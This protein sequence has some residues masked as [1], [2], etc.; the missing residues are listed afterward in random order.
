MTTML[1]SDSVKAA[2]LIG[3]VGVILLA[4]NNSV[5][6]WDQDEA[7]YAGF[8]LNIVENGD[9]LI[10]DF[11]WSDVH[12]KPPLHFWNIALSYKVFGI[13]EF[14]VRLPSV[15]FILLT[16][17]AMYW[18]GRKVFG[19]RQSLYGISILATSFLVPALAKI[20]VTDGTLLFFTTLCA[21]AILNVLLYRNWVWVIVFW[22]SLSLALLTKG[23]PVIL[24]AGGF[25]LLAL[26]FHPQRKNLIILHPWF[27]LP[28]SLLPL[29]AWAFA[30]LQ[31]PQGKVFIEWMLDWY[32]LKRIGGSVFGQTGPPG[33]HL[34]GI[35][36]FFI[37]YFIFLPGAFKELVMGFW[38]GD[39]GPK[40][41]LGVWFIAGWFIFE[42]SPSKL[43][44]YVVAAHVP[45]AL[46]I[47]S[48]LA[49]GKK[50]AG[51][52]K[53]IQVIV[54]SLLIA[55]LAIAPLI[56][57]LGLKSKTIVLLSA[58]AMVVGLV[59]AFREKH[60]RFSLSNRIIAFNFLFQSIFWI[61]V[62]PTI[63][64]LKNS[65]LKV[66][67]IAAN[68]AGRDTGVILA[69]SFSNPPSLPFY[70]RQRFDNLLEEYDIDNLFVLHESDR[71]FLF[72]LTKE[73]KDL[74]EKRYGNIE[75]VEIEASYTDRFEK[76]TYYL[77]LNK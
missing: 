41:L 3:M 7:A 71:R 38:T 9:W 50:P 29:F 18:G 19:E 6:L 43:P 10:P 74:L 14:A 62:L 28:L 30:C 4:N 22:I 52:Y 65:T 13:N 17:V 31:D 16:L 36:I 56:L 21:L 2:I 37:P 60:C 54:W 26:I 39:R 25:G 32:I 67:T 58:A 63:E 72:V 55:A 11:T 76:G 44:A 12:R 70:L 53:A 40:F 69:N 68:M 75:Y 33:T 42:L 27:F 59:F 77:H 23:P 48:Q 49:Q 20:S 35:V 8:A 47:G 57:D 15:L 45:L 61:A 1:R 46:I 64:P 24:F 34:L 51:L 73:Q 5:S 66:A